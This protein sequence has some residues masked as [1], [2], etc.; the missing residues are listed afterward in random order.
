MSSIKIKSL[1]KSQL[2]KVILKF[3][4]LNFNENNYKNLAMFD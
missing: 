2:L 3:F 1:Q 4:S